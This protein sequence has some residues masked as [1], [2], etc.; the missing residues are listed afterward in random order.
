[1]LKKILLVCFIACAPLLAE[2]K[3]L[4]FAGSTREDSYNKKLVKEAAEIA[5]QMG[6]TVTLIDL[7]DYPMPLYE[8]DL[9]AK[10]GMPSN[11]K[12]FRDLLISNNAII[13]ASPE[14]NGSISGL[15]KNAIDWATR[16]E[17]AKPSRD[18]FK[19]K[20]FAIMSA[21][22]G[23]NGGANGLIHL[24]DILKGLGGEVVET[25]V[26][27]SKAHSAFN[28]KG[29]LENPALQQKLQMEIEQLLQA[30]VVSAEMKKSV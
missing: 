7:K 14:Y 24:R 9:E 30:K 26:S 15:L 6:A 19:G 3:V 23:G 29:H 13:I 21:S 8:G 11:A 20:R 17:R 1:M 4:A 2:E 18:A 12:R 10:Q 27:I 25:Q 22:P 16:T 28:D 5:K